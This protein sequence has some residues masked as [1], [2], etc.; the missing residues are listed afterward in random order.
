MKLRRSFSVHCPVTW[1]LIISEVPAVLLWTS[2]TMK[3]NVRQ[4]VCK[5]KKYQSLKQEEV[6]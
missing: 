2:G 1:I 4:S 6:L 5:M 3:D